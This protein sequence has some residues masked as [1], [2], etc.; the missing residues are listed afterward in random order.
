[1]RRIIICLYIIEIKTITQITVQTTAKANTQ[2]RPY[3]LP[4]LFGINVRIIKKSCPSDHKSFCTGFLIGFGESF[5]GTMKSSTSRTNLAG[6]K[7]VKLLRFQIFKIS[8]LYACMAYML[9]IITQRYSKNHFQQRI[10][11]QKTH[12]PIFE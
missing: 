9:I 3:T 2:V 1:L 7:K 4:G 6:H 5:F 11:L 12:F 10:S 8:N